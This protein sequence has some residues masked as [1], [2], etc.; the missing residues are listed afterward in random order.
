MPCHVGTNT[1]F[2]MLKTAHMVIVM[3]AQLDLAGK[4]GLGDQTQFLITACQPGGRG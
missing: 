2:F 4:L 3:A 1:Q